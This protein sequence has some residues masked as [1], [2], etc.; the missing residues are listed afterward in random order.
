MRQN[1][2][3]ELVEDAGEIAN[4]LLALLGVLIH[5][6]NAENKLLV[7]D[8]ALRHEVLETLPVLGRE[9]CGQFAE[10]SDVILLELILKVSLSIL[11]AVLGQ[12]GVDVERPFGRCIRSDVYLLDFLFGV[13]AGVLDLLIESEHLVGLKLAVADVGLIDEE[14]DI[15]V[16]LFVDYALEFVGSQRGSYGRSIGESGRGDHTVG[17]LDARKH[18]L[19]VALAY[20]ERK[21]KLAAHHLRLIGIHHRDG[22]R[23]TVIVADYRGIAAHLLPLEGISLRGHFLTVETQIGGYGH[24]R[25]LYEELCR[26]AGRHR[27]G[28]A[29]AHH[30]E[31]IG[32]NGKIVGLKL[33]ELLAATR[34]QQSA[35]CGHDC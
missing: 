22:N 24:L 6:E 17:N 18:I 20:I 9:I 10:L 8:I 33:V 2:I 13:A 23:A 21:F 16:I 30:F 32:I 11:L 4:L 5:R 35:C 28:N 7:L 27:S 29:I 14:V 25:V 12:T 31:R 1:L 34:K 26:N 15:G 19:L 3:G